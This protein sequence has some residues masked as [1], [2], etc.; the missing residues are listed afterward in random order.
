MIKNLLPNKLP[1]LKDFEFSAYKIHDWKDAENEIY[2]HTDGIYNGHNR[3]HA[4]IDSL[5][6]GD[7]DTIEIRNIN[8]LK[9]NTGTDEVWESMKADPVW[10]KF[11]QYMSRGKINGL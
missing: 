4:P 7:I 8:R 6:A 5:L 3:I 2:I 11:K 1:W 9:V 10:D